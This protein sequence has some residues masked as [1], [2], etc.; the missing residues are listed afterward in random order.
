MRRIIYDGNALVTSV[1]VADAVIAYAAEVIRLGTSST[2]DI[3]VLESNG[4]IL[5]HTILIG[6]ATQLEVVDIDGESAAVSEDDFEMPAFA[7]L[8]SVGAPVHSAAHDDL[9][10]GMGDDLHD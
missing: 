4:T 5:Q 10:P 1:S 9:A 7:P 8:L 6:P 3:P 2:V